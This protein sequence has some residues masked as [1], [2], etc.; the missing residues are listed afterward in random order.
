MNWISLRRNYP[1]GKLELNDNE[2]GQLKLELK[3][4]LWRVEEFQIVKD[5]DNLEK[6]ARESIRKQ[7]S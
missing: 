6:T 7:R 1:N 2:A 4:K 3:N 5:Y